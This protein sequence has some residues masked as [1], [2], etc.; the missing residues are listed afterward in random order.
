MGALPIHDA[1]ALGKLSALVWL[2]RNAQCSLMDRDKEGAT[3]LHVAS[4]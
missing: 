2:V 1:A 4:R 3:V